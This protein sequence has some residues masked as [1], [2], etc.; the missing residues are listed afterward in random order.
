MMEPRSVPMDP[1]KQPITCTFVILTR[2]TL[3]V[4]EVVNTWSGSAW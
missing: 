1:H 4:E 3:A 2:T